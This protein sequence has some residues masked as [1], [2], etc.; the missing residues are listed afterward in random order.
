MIGYAQLLWNLNPHVSLLGDLMFWV[1][2]VG[3]LREG[4]GDSNTHRSTD[5]VI[6]YFLIWHTE[7]LMNG[8]LVF[9]VDIF[10]TT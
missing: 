7:C 10:G 3:G 4:N 5:T 1:F 8:V 6:I 2:W 9:N